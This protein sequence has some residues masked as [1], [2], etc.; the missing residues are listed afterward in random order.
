MRGKKKD[1]IKG[2]LL[3]SLPV[4][5]SLSVMFLGRKI[6]FLTVA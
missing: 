2:M 4:E 1:D 6:H 5:L 3:F